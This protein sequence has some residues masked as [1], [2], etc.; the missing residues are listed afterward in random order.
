MTK[1]QAIALMKFSLF[2]IDAIRGDLG[3]FRKNGY[4]VMKQG[5]WG[6]TRWGLTSKGYRACS[7]IEARLLKILKGSKNVA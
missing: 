3:W 4:I 5:P 6:K 1:K 2:G 7:K